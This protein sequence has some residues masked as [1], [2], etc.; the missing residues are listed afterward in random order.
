MKVPQ[1][2]VRQKQ[3]AAHGSNGTERTEYLKLFEKKDTNKTKGKT[4]EKMGER[5]EHLKW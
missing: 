1:R 4:E 5:R 2:G 3:K